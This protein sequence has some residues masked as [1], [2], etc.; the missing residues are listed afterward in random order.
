MAQ[1]DIP[2]YMQD[3]Y[4][5][6]TG[7]RMGIKTNNLELVVDSLNKGATVNW[8]FRQL[9]TPETDPKIVELLQ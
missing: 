3:R 9:I 7:L 4:L 5:F 6:N 8:F 1:K 2:K